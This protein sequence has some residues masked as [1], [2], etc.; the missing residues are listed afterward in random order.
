MRKTATNPNYIHKEINGVTDLGNAFP[1]LIQNLL[2]SNRTSK[3]LK[4]KMQQI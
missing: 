4:I 2:P 1:Y 3:N